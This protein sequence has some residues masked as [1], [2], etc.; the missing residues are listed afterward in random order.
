MKAI[1]NTNI[2]TKALTTKKENSLS[3][4]HNVFFNTL[5]I[6]KKSFFAAIALTL[7]NLVI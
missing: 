2:A 5:R 6:S 3:I 7:L 1:V 4:I